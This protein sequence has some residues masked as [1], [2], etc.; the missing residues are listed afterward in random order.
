MSSFYIPWKHQQMFLA[1]TLVR[2]KFVNERHPFVDLNSSVANEKSRRWLLS[3]KNINKFKDNLRK[4]KGKIHLY[5][6]K[7]TDAI[8]DFIIIH[9][10][11]ESSKDSIRIFDQYFCRASLYTLS[12]PVITCSKLTIERLEQGIKYVQS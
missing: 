8:K 3:Q 9:N 11:W 1:L 12:Q 6:G 5:L 7:I 4:S 10:F 2:D